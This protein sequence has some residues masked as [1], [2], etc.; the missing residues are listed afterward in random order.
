MRKRGSLP[1]ENLD[2]PVYEAKP[3]K[4]QKRWVIQGSW[5]MSLC[6]IFFGIVTRYFLVGV[7][8]VLFI[9]AL[10]MDKHV[11][12]TVRGIETYYNMRITTHY[13]IWKWSE[14]DVIAPGDKRSREHP[15]LIPLFFRRG[16]R[17]RQLNFTSGE[18]REIRK[19]AKQ[20]NRKIVLG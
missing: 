15:E 20:Q 3:M 7:F 13:E 5:V 2:G 11:V 12:V 14:I 9:L 10:L 17:A 16:D 19:L 6:L 18:V 8:G 1:W 4:E